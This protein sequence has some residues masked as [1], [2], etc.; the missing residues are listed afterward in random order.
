MRKFEDIRLTEEKN[1]LHHDN[2]PNQ[3]VRNF[4]QLKY[5]L[6]QYPAYPSYFHGKRLP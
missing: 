1:I 4:N 2:A 3:S 5:E 6:L